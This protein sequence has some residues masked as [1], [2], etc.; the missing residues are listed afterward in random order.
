M[1]SV[2]RSSWVTDPSKGSIWTTLWSMRF[3]TMDN[4]MREMAFAIDLN[5]AKADGRWAAHTG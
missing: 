5:D 3:T 2:D 1:W 4:E